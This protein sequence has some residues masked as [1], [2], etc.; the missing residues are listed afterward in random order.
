[1]AAKLV[2]IPSAEAP[3]MPTLPFDQGCLATHSTVS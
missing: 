1:M 2:V 3:T